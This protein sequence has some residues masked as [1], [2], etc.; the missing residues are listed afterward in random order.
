M[1]VANATGCSSIYGGNL[2]T[3]PWTFN[4]DGRGPTWSNSLFE[5][6]AEFG[7][8]FRLTIDKQNEHAKELLKN[9][10]SEVGNNLA[11]EILNADQSDEAGI[12]EQRKRVKE[13]KDKLEKILYQTDKVK[14]V[15]EI[16]QLKEEL[17]DFIAKEYDR[18][19]KIKEAE[20]YFQEEISNIVR[21]NI[22]QNEKREDNRTLNE[23]RIIQC[24]TG[25]L[26]R[27]HGSGLFSRGQTKSLSVLTLGEP[28]Y[29][30]IYDEMEI[31]GEKRFMHHYNFPP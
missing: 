24:E 8:G 14:R 10:S 31:V 26:P 21:K 4:N 1:L 22:L 12:F 25:L 2:P 13:L 15:E 18:V 5:D 20:D 11:E 19:E 28:K 9:L 17:I 30:Q 29:I 7:F 6:N 16:K 3:T 23:I 27:T